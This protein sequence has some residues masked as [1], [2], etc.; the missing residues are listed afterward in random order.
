M[1]AVS[2]L[3]VVSSTVASLRGCSRWLDEG[4]PDCDDY[5]FPVEPHDNLIELC[6]PRRIRKKRYIQIYNRKGRICGTVPR[7]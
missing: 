5:G 3:D 4:A 6:N 2:V 7:L 1:V